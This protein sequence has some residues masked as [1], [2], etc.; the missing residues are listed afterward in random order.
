VI[1]DEASF[2]RMVKLN[3][4]KPAN[5]KCGWERTRLPPRWR[6]AREFKPDLPV[7]LDRSRLNTMDRGDVH[8]IKRD[9]GA[10]KAT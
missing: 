7:L 4:R 8:Q 2:A 5:S 1:D 6:Q 3:L 9:S 10:L